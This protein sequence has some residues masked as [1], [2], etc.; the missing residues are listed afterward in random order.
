M[1]ITVPLLAL[2]ISGCVPFTL[3]KDPPPI[4]PYGFYS[5]ARCRILKRSAED[6]AI[7][8]IKIVRIDIPPR[9]RDEVYELHFNASG[10]SDTSGAYVLG[11]RSLV[12]RGP[13]ARPRP[14]RTV[15]VFN[16][17]N[18][19]YVLNLR[20]DVCELVSEDNF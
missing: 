15:F 9:I 8:D 18:R 13:T 4:I 17:G 1:K 6:T 16:E 14:A 12:V 5:V 11:L 19:P 7:V 2:L 10:V 20:D 3:H